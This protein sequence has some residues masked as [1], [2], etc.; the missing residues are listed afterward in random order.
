M[1]KVRTSAKIRDRDRGY[2]RI[3][4][5]VA[6]MTDLD[7]EVGFFTPDQAAKAAFAEFGSESVPARPFMSA[8][9][10]GGRAQIFARWTELLGQVVDGDLPEARALQLLADEIKAM[11]RA[12]IDNGR[13]TPNAASTIQPKKSSKPLVDTGAMRD[14]IEVKIK[15]G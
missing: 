14:A 12:S 5:A 1:P 11:I 10:D 13:W 15:P 3:R 9:L 2:K 7:A 8:A 6:A 4:S